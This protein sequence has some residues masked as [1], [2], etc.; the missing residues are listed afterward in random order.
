MNVIPATR[1]DT[2]TFF[3]T[4]LEPWI[5]HAKTLGVPEADLEALKLITESARAAF[6]AQQQAASAAQA[7]TQ[8]YHQE[9]DAMRALG[10][11]IVARI[12]VNAQTARDPNLYVLAQVP[13]PLPRGRANTAAPVPAP[14]A[15]RLR[16][17]ASGAVEV[18]WEAAINRRT[19][20]SVYRTL[21]GESKATLLGSVAAKSFT[22]TTVPRGTTHAVYHVVAQRGTTQSQSSP[23]VSISFGSVAGRAAA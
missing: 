19:F 3:E 6:V 17:S 10:A 15:V 22:D 8:R 11:A 2:L 4:H 12:K 13:P 21:P 18:S 7:A 9:A 14:T 20:F 23:N 5:T 1:T 16:M